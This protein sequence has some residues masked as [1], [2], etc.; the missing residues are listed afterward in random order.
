VAGAA[1]GTVDA[2]VPGWFVT[3][4]TSTPASVAAAAASLLSVGWE[5]PG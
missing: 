5:L 2:P 3:V 4:S 1:A